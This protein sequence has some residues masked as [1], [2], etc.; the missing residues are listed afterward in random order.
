MGKCCNA[1]PNNRGI[2]IKYL[3]SKETK[4]IILVSLPL[5]NFCV[6]PAEDMAEI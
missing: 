4:A 5:F 2:F 1:F 3:Q 6:I